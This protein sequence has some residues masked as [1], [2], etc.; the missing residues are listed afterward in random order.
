MWFTPDSCVLLT[1][2]YQFC[3][4]Q[5]FHNLTILLLTSNRSLNSLDEIKENMSTKCF[6]FLSLVYMCFFLKKLLLIYMDRIRGTVGIRRCIPLLVRKQCHSKTLLLPIF[7]LGNI[8]TGQKCNP[9]L[10][11]PSLLCKQQYKPGASVR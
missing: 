5:T 11:K 1:A 9:I 6:S 7:L 4:S 2:K 3:S 8:K 10:K